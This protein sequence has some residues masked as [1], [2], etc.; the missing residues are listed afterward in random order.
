MA[1]PPDVLVRPGTPTDVN[2]AS[3][4]VAQ[5][6]AA[7]LS[8]GTGDHSEG[9]PEVSEAVTDGSRPPLGPTSETGWERTRERLADER[10]FFFVAERADGAIVGAAAGMGGRLDGGRGEAIPGLCHVSMVS[11]HPDEWGRGI[12]GRLLSAVMAEAGERGL[13]RIQLFT[14]D[15]NFRARALYERLGFHL[16]GETAISSSAEHIVRYLLLLPPT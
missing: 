12:G 5:A 16:T 7:R 14:H 15:D 8:P 1:A 3:L 4:V 6:D 2:A 9:H 13:E 10:T 11:V